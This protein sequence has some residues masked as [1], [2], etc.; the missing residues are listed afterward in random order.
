VLYYAVAGGGVVSLGA[1]PA[2]PTGDMAGYFERSGSTAKGRLDG[3][4]DTGS[5]STSSLGTSWLLGEY[6]GAPGT[7]QGDIDVKEI[8]ICDAAVTGSDF[9]DLA[10]YINDE[11]GLTL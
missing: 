11:Y 5:C 1:I 8:I 10:T 7:Y 9:T 6:S 3:T 2:V 4:E